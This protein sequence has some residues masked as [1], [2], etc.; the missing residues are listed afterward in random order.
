MGR[1]E[2]ETDRRREGKTTSR[3]GQ[4]WSLP[5]PSG[6]WRTE[7][8]EETDC[9]VICGTPTTL[10]VKGYVKVKVRDVSGRRWWCPE[11]ISDDLKMWELCYECRISCP[12]S[13][14]G[15]S[16]QDEFCAWKRPLMISRRGH[17]SSL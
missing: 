10:A 5:S 17:Q 14:A 3:D 7:K 15:E 9:E 2:D 4:E 12:S 8:M 13:S 16:G 1:E 11:T 6:Q